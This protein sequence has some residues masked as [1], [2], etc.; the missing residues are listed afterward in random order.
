MPE[1]LKLED[2]MWVIEKDERNGHNYVHMEQAKFLISEI[3]KRDE[4]LKLLDK[5][6]KDN[7]C[8]VNSNCICHELIT[9][10]DQILQ[11]N[12]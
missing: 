2:V 3:R 9:K 5:A 6:I 11:G 7:C 4:A 12:K 8:C 1:E 10:K